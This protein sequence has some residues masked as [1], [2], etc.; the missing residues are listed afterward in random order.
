MCDLLTGEI[1]TGYQALGSRYWRGFRGGAP[2]ARPLFVLICKTKQINMRPRF[3]LNPVAPQGSMFSGSAP[4]LGDMFL[5][6][7]KYKSTTM[8]LALSNILT[9]TQFKRIESFYWNFPTSCKRPYKICLCKFLNKFAFRKHANGLRN[10]RK[11][12]QSVT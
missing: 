1:V 3:T 11:L 7:Q 9:Q 6:K 5:A 8:Y 4:A 10:S 12:P 2:G